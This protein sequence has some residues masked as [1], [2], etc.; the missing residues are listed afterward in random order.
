M[1]GQQGSALV[2][3]ARAGQREAFGELVKRHQMAMIAVARAY[4]A[5][6]HDAEDAVQEAFVKAFCGI[7]TLKAD[8]AFA[9]WLTTI[10][11]RTCIDTLRTRRDKLALEDFASTARLRLRV[12]EPELTP[13]TATSRAEMSD[14][15]KA[16]VG[17]LPEEQRVALLLHY[18]EDMT[19][20][21][22][23]EYLDL[24]EPTV[25]GR[26]RRAKKALKSV[27][28]ALAPGGALEVRWGEVQ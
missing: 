3:L 2:S 1:P 11:V 21:E 5:S 8:G 20:R 25:Q 18:G 23:G 26:L 4:F 7:G 27:L 28:R 17:T 19:Y 9:S 24:P 14:L 13:A 16:A 10:T 15:V 12:G 6:E 22:I